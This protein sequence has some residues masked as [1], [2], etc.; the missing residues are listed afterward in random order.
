MKATSNI[1]IQQVISSL[2]LN[3]LGIYSRDGTFESDIG[4]VNLHPAKGTHWVAYM[5]LNC[6][7]SYGCS[8]P[9]KLSNLIIIR[10]EYCVYS[11]Y[12]TQGLTNKKVSFCASYC[13]Y[14]L[15]L[16]KVKGSD[17]KPAVLNF[18]Y[19]RFY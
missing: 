18:Y 3:D 4:I 11:E 7:D 8:P 16:T 2:F 10:N 17:F 12:K 9:Q 1:K 5:N 6:F 13:L 19:E 14:L 15:Y